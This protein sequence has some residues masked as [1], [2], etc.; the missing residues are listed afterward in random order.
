M[1]VVC[2]RLGYLAMEGLFGIVLVARFYPLQVLFIMGLLDVELYALWR[3]VL[4]LE[5]LRVVGSILEGDSKIIV[6]WAAGSPCPWYYL[7]KINR[8]RHYIRSFRYSLS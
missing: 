8:I 6:S 7:N 1:G 4:A 3:G 2:K 5:E